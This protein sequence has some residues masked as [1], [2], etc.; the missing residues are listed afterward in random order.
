MKT[1]D[2]TEAN[3]VAWDEAAPLHRGQNHDD[4]LS[5][6]QASDYSCLDE[7]ETA[8]LLNLGVAGKDVAQLCCNNGC[9]VLSV[10]NLGAA[11]CVG[12]DQSEGFIEQARELAAAGSIDCEFVCT[13][14]YDIDAAYDADFDIVTVTIGDLSWMPDLGGF[15]TV[16]ARM[17]KPGGALF[18]YEQHPIIEMIEP[19]RAGDALLWEYSYFKH[20]PF[21]DTDGL[22][23][24]GGT[25]Y[26]SKPLY[27]FLHKMSDVIMAGINAGLAVEHFEER[28]NHI[29]N[30]WYNAEARQP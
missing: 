20:E 18:I 3:R 12:F 11:R 4:L 23:Y 17:L 16:A 14:I 22:D 5:A 13:D 21:V 15:F 1:K 10:K 25:T 28:P 27:S 19:G 29:S 26:E 6:F 9:E 8:R 30:T 2:F 7:I 24:Y